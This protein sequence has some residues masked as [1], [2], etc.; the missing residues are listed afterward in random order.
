MK[1]NPD[2]SWKNLCDVAAELDKFAPVLLSAETGPEGEGCALKSI[3]SSMLGRFAPKNG[4]VRAGP[5]L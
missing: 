5:S 3:C 2:Q 4:R 1:N